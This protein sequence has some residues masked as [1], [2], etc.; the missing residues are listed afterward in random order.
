MI[1]FFATAQHINPI[2]NYL[3]DWSDDLRVQIDIATYEGFAAG[4]MS[5]TAGTIIF[6]DIER[7]SHAGIRMGAGL[8]DAAQEKGR[9]VLNNP[10]LVMSKFE[11]LKKLHQLGINDFAVYPVGI[12]PKKWPVFVRSK[13]DH[14]GQPPLLHNADELDAEYDR[15]AALGVDLDNMMITE[16][17]DVKEKGYHRSYSFMRIGDTYIPRHA[18]SSDKWIVRGSP[19]ELAEERDRHELD[20]EEHLHHDHL[21]LLKPIYDMANIQYGRID[22]GFADGKLQ[23]FEIN[24]HPM[25][26]LLKKRVAPERVTRATLMSNRISAAFNALVPEQEPVLP[27]LDFKPSS[28]DKNVHVARTT[29]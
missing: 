23:V 14:G 29:R 9:T 26:V 3:M 2:R 1:N 28:L 19:V 15:L 20:F 13:H 6:G 7:L 24:T 12:K 21:P 16:Y 5:I 11:L 27:M 10:G 17:I 8:A 22:Y 4:K 18:H 25:L